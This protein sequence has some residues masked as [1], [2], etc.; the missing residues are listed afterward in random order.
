MQKTPCWQE[1]CYTNW[2]VLDYL[3]TIIANKNLDP[4]SSNVLSDKMCFICFV[5]I[6]VVLPLLRLQE[7][8][9]QSTVT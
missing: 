9:A 6:I 3:L 4:Q 7:I 8:A 1:K 2:S 5:M